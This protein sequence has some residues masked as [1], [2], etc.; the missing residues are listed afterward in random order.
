MRAGEV[1]CP[2][3]YSLSY[4]NGM[5]ADLCRKTFV[6]LFLIGFLAGC[7]S[8]GELNRVEEDSYLQVKIHTGF[9]ES[10]GFKKLN[11]RQS[12]RLCIQLG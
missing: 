11:A 8:G 9:M 3:I 4:E 6:G 12:G 1:S 10:A 5:S 2:T 7:S